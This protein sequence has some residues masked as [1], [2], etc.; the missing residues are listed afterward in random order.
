MKEKRD[1]E[2]EE[3]SRK[4][5]EFEAKILEREQ[6]KKE[7]IEKQIVKKEQ[8]VKVVKA[9]QLEAIKERKVILQDKRDQK[10]KHLAE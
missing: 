1:R 10:K 8:S 7:I 2:R 9:R 4:R 6:S 3:A 5:I